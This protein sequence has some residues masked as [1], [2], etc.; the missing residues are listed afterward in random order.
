MEKIV[1]E[2]F[3]SSDP[4]PSSGPQHK[5]RTFVLRLLISVCLVSFSSLIHANTQPSVCGAEVGRSSHPRALKPLIEKMNLL[6]LSFELNFEQGE[7]G[8]FEPYFDIFAKTPPGE[9]V[10]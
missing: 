2:D 9:V 7:G 1:Q 6:E 10:G 8:R 3:S 4:K 5:V